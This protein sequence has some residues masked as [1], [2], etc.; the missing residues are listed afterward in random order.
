[1]NNAYGRRLPVSRLERLLN[2]LPRQSRLGPT[3]PRVDMARM[4]N[5]EFRQ[6]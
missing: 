5:V 1:M 2:R 4:K 6:T 3:E